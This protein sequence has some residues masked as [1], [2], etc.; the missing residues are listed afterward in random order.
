MGNL[1]WS[2]D[3]SLDKIEHDKIPIWIKMFNVPLEAWNNKGISALASSVG[4]PMI[5][6][7][8]TAE[9]C[10]NASGK[11]AYAR[12]L[13]EVDA[14]KGLK[15]RIEIQYKNAQQSVVRTRYVKVEYP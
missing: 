15:D 13:V 14:K 5:M 11:F 7:K 10:M 12:V 6:D 9:M 2:P 3:V 8:M 1:K 4:K